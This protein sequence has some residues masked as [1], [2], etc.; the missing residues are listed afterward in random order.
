MRIDEYR[1]ILN[2]FFSTKSEVLKF[3]VVQ[4]QYEVGFHMTASP[5]GV[6]PFPR[7]CTTLRTVDPCQAESDMFSRVNS[8]GWIRSSGEMGYRIWI[9]LSVSCVS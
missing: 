8:C 1:F 3:D 2:N 9:S 6:W 4:V 7:I 5:T